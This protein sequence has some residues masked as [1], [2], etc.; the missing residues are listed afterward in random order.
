MAEV[1]LHPEA[2][3]DYRVA[4]GWYQQRSP[5]VARRFVAEVGRVV[6][7]IGAHPER[8]GWHDEDFRAASVSRFPFLLIFRVQTTGKVL[9]VA[10]AHTSREPGYWRDRI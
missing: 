4:V 6:D 1:V 8:F 10:V 7:Q 5:A 3:R 9:V 2:R